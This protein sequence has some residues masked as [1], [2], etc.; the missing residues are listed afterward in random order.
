ME[1]QH[2]LLNSNSNELKLWKIFILDNFSMELS[3]ANLNNG[4]MED[5]E[6][7]AFPF[8]KFMLIAYWD[9]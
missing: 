2:Y 9:S 1:L 6:I 8:L 7:K 3:R 5:G 4:N